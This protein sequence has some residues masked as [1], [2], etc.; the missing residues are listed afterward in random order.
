M[1]EALT[2]LHKTQTVH[3]NTQK[4]TQTHQ[5]RAAPSDLESPQLELIVTII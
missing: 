5:V 2:P 1:P 4:E 3:N